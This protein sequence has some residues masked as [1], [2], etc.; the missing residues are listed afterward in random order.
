MTSRHPRGLPR[1]A[2]GIG[3]ALLF[4]TPVAA[5]DSEV[6]R[7]RKELGETKQELQSTKDTLDKLE[8][9]VDSLQ[10]APPAP[11]APT[12][13]AQTSSVSPTARLAPVN[14][15]NPAISFVVDT[16]FSHDASSSWQSIGYPNGADFSLKTGELFIS[17]PID[18]FVRGYA[19]INGTSDSGFDI[20]EAALITTALPWNLTVKGG[21]FF[22]DVGR[23]PHWHDEALPVRRP[24][25][26]DR[27]P[28]RRRIQAEGVEVSWLAPIEH[29]IEL[30]GGLY[31][32]VGAERQRRSEHERLLRPARL[33]RADVCWCT[34]H[35]Y[36][37]LTDT[38]NLELGGSWVDGPAGATSATSTAV[39]A[40]AAPP[41][42][43]ERRLPGLRGRARSGS[44]TTRSFET[45]R[46]GPTRTR[47]TRSSRP[48]PHRTA[49]T[50]T[51][52][53]SSTAATRSASAA[54]TPRIALRRRRTP[55]T[56]HV[57]GRFA[58]WMPSEFQRLRFQF[59][60]ST[61]AIS[62]ANQR[63]TTPVDRFPRESQPW[64]RACA[65]HSRSRRVRC[66]AARARGGPAAAT[67]RVV[68]STPD[69][70]DMTRQIGGERVSVETIA[71]GNQDPHK[72]PVKPSFVTKLN[73][74]DALVVKV[75]A[76]STPSCP[77]LL[78]VARNPKIMPDGSAYIDASLYVRRSRCRP[79]RTA[80]RASC[81]RSAI[82][83]SASIRCAAS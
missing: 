2:L 57:L 70:A 20:E 53:P 15:D 3:A 31:N 81:T 44:G 77:A 65:R 32:T 49:A 14:I 48:A 67:L 24:P 74:A 17:A 45:S 12:T 27:P 73:R 83:T 60:R 43:H 11:T 78:E 66:T 29:Y 56:A 19:A 22:A 79:A 7:L 46:S 38:L 50:R 26:L 36:F 25:A 59:D 35:T 72:V 61:G 34:P 1:A 4:A 52:R 80:R 8:Q 28:D 16:A 39:D 69:V 42:G 6:E 13:A 55:A 75:S 5:A 33:Q 64:L 63:F 54:T 58:T 21:R 37:D 10:P 47:A 9:R 40:D 62:T 23:L 76:S 71:E 82:R 30:T 51:S 41:A 18:P 68:A